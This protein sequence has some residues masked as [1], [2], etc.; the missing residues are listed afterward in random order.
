MRKLRLSSIAVAMIAVFILLLGTVG[1]AFACTGL[2]RDD[3]LHLATTVRTANLTPVIGVTLGVDKST[4]VPGDTLTYTALVTNS[5]VSLVVTGQISAKNESSRT[6]TVGSW[7]DYISYDPKGKG[8]D[9]DDDGYGHDR[10]RWI[11]IAGAAGAAAGHSPAVKPPLSTGMTFAATPI[12]SSDVTYA[13]GA[14]KIDGTQIGRDATAR[15]SFTATIPLTAASQRS[16][17]T[18][19]TASS[20]LWAPAPPPTSWSRSPCP[21][22]PPPP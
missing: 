20:R 22:R 19:S 21:T 15:C 5:G 1:Q 12:A 16:P 7:F 8:G 6:A 2:E 13:A 4:A 18:T 11:P 14:D 3:N 17:R 9:R 10:D